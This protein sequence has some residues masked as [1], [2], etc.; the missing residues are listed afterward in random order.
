MESG[1]DASFVEA[2]FD[3]ARL[4]CISALERAR[5]WAVVLVQLDKTSLATGKG[6]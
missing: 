5:N 2:D 1:G 3:E 4:R 6:L